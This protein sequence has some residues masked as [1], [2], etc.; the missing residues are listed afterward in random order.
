MNQSRTC[1]HSKERTKGKE[2]I[3]KVAAIQTEPYFGEKE[4]NIQRQLQLI[5]KA[6][7]EGVLLLTLPELASTEYVFNTREELS[8]LAEDIPQG[9]TC[10]SWIRTCKKRQIYVCGGLA[11]RD[12]DKFFNITVLIGPDGFIGK[13][14][15][16]HLWDEEKLFFEPGD[17]G[18]P[19]FYFPFGRVGM[20]VCYDGWY[21]EV[22]RILALNN[23]KGRVT[24]AC[25]WV[26]VKRSL[27]C[28][29]CHGF[30]RGYLHSSPM[31]LPASDT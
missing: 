28:F 30:S 23:P 21:S 4:K 13:Y 15:K 25:P 20:I 27:N 14:R 16:V 5:E 17:L 3:I 6:G 11:Q 31:I 26:N 12:G 18:F 19:I 8:K 7:N 10:Q 22:S 29:E 2:S 24:R 9:D 1:C